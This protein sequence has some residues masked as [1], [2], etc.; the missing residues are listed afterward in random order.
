MSIAASVMASS[1][2]SMLPNV[3]MSQRASP[4]SDGWPSC[5]V[6]ISVTRRNRS[7][8]HSHRCTPPAMSTSSSASTII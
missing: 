7:T 2:S 6:P 5:Q 1:T 4:S 3:T 8:Q